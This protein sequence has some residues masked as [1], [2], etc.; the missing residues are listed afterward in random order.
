MKYKEL[1]DLERYKLIQVINT[2]LPKKYRNSGYEVWKKGIEIRTDNWG[3]CGW[4]F[5]KLS[6]AIE[7]LNNKIKK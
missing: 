4:T 5:I 6:N 1:L 3:N 7:F 2:Q